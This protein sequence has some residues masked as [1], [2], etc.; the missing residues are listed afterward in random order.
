MLVSRFS[1]SHGIRNAWQDLNTP[2][3]F[4]ELHLNLFR[5]LSAQGHR[6]LEE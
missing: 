4:P 6:N 1:L 3:D 5:L 2:K